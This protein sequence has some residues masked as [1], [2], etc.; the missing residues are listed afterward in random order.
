M[1][2]L[3]QSLL[4]FVTTK[5]IPLLFLIAEAILPSMLSLL[6]FVTTKAIHIRIRLDAYS[7]H[8]TNETQCCCYVPKPIEM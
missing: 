4:V 2:P 6:V 5:A 1:E 8:K 3:P 7:F